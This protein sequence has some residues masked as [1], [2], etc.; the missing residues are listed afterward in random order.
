MPVD[1][2][3]FNRQTRI[4]LENSGRIDPERIE[5]Y[6]ARDGYSALAEALTE[7]TPAQVVERITQSGLRG[8]GGAGYPTGLKWRTVVKASGGHRRSD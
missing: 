3:F 7:L 8:R 2:P 6:I 5:E 1:V 4:V